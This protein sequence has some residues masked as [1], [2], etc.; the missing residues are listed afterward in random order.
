MELSV[1]DRQFVVG[2]SEI[3]LQPFQKCGLKDSAAAIESVAGQPDQFR[4]AKPEVAR[5]LQ[6]LDQFFVREMSARTH[7]K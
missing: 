3:A 4:P 1:L 2:Q 7:W 5:V 6:L